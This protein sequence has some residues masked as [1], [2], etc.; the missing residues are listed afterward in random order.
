LPAFR[1][2]SLDHEQRTVIVEKLSFG[3][4]RDAFTNVIDQFSSR[5]VNAVENAMS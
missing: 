2:Q 4:V 3:E 1:L 5:Q